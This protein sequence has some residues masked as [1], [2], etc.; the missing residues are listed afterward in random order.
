MSSLSISLSGKKF[1]ASLTNSTTLELSEG[2]LK[3]SFTK[4]RES[5]SEEEEVVVEEEELL[6]RRLATL[7]FEAKTR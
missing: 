2:I 1:V 3:T 6:T 7:G 4:K 5:E